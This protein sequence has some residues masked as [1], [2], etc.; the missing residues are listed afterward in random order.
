MEFTLS[1]FAGR[2]M[3]AAAAVHE[4]NRAAM[5]AAAVPK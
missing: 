3:G 4:G 1:G 2:M 5:E